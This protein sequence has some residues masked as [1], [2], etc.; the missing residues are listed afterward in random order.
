M[1]VRIYNISC[2]HNIF[3]YREY[4]CCLLFVNV[5]YDTCGLALIE[6]K[7]VTYGVT[8]RAYRT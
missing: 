8:Y 2:V 3:L 4:E 5:M 6:I 1:H 7:E